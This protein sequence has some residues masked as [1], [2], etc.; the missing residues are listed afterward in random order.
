MLRDLGGRDGSTPKRLDG[1]SVELGVGMS[2][3][4]FLV[5]FEDR[6]RACLGYLHSG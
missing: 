1:I 2:A 4:K 6:D 5:E 3:T